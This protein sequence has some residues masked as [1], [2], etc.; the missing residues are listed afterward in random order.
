MP[1][2]AI[3]FL[4]TPFSMTMEVMRNPELGPTQLRKVARGNVARPQFFAAIIA[5]RWASLAAAA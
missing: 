1:N 5:V 4:K 3:A 2:R